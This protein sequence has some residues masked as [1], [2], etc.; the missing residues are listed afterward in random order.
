MCCLEYLI[1]KPI[2]LIH[3]IYFCCLGYELCAHTALIF[4]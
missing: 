2:E 1:S 3:I 4:F